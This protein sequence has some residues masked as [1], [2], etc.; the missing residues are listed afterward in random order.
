MNTD[1][2]P[3]R[4]VTTVALDVGVLMSLLIL[5]RVGILGDLPGYRFVVLDAV[6]QEIGQL[7]QQTVLAAAFEHEFVDR[8]DAATTEEL[9]I[10]AQHTAAMGLSEA[11]CLAASEHRG[12][13][14]ASDDRGLFRFNAGI[15]LG[16]SRILTTN[17]ILTTA[18]RSGVIGVAELR[19]AVSMLE[20]NAT[21]GTHRPV[22]RAVPQ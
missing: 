20:R 3:T 6:E 19:D 11:A 17:D 8:P 9:R 4:R 21:S 12:W 16:V 10:F 14:L 22:L 13:F 1:L 18:L 15:R 2:S 5:N 7:R